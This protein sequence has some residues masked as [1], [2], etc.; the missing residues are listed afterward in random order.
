MTFVFATYFSQ[1]IALDP[2]DGTAEWGWAMTVSALAIAVLSPMLGAI[3]DAGGRR[4]PWLVVFTLLDRRRL[5]LLW[6]ARPDHSFVA[7]HAGVVV[8]ANVAFEIARSSTTRCCR[9]SSAATTSAAC[10]A[11]AGGSAMPAGSPA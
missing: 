4:K 3:A 11:G 7:L 9:R 10:R 8:L 2:V 5:L 1:G 6:Y